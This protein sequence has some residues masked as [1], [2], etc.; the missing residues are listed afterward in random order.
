MF[1]CLCKYICN[2]VDVTIYITVYIYIRRSPLILS[3]TIV[4]RQHIF[5]LLDAA[6]ARIFEAA[7]VEW[8]DGHFLAIGINSVMLAV[9]AS[10]VQFC[11]SSQYN[12]IIYGIRSTMV[13]FLFY[14]NCLLLLQIGKCLY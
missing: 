2:F 12:C 13:L 4:Y 5:N 3:Y 8:Q 10:L 6:N 11:L 14:N 1:F 9:V 7:S